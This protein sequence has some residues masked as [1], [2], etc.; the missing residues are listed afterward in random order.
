MCIVNLLQQLNEAPSSHDFFTEEKNIP[1]FS[2]RSSHS[3]FS[4]FSPFFIILPL[5]PPFSHLCKYVYLSPFQ[6]DTYIHRT[7]KQKINKSTHHIMHFVLLIKLHCSNFHQERIF[8]HTFSLFLI[9]KARQIFL[10]FSQFKKEPQ[11]EEGQEG[12]KNRVFLFSRLSL[13]FSDFPSV[14]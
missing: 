4:R 5:S 10:Y 9:F 1:F 8:F 3:I 13:F 14:S 2:P 11:T 7:T 6:N 12:E